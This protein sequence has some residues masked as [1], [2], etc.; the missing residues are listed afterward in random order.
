MTKLRSLLSAVLLPLTVHAQPAGK[1]QRIG[2][3][4]LGGAYE[5]VLQGMR[6]GMKD[7][8]LT[9]GKHFVLHI[10]DTRGSLRD[11][12]NSAKQLVNERVDLLFT[13]TTSATLAT[14]KATRDIPIVFYAGNDPVRAGL[15]QSF[16]QPGDRLT[17]VHHRSTDLTAKRL[18]AVRRVLPKARRIVMFFNPDLGSA[19]DGMTFAR[20]VAPKLGFEIVER[21]VKSA[22]ELLAGVRALRA[23]EVD[24]FVTSGDAIQTSAMPQVLPLARERNLPVV[25]QDLNLVQSGALMAYGANYLDVGRSAAKPIQRILA[26]AKPQDI[27]VEIYDKVQL[28]LNL[29]VARELGL[30]IPQ[31]V[32]LRADQ[33]IH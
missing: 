27:P 19:R 13:I 18:E 3:I 33:V 11:V 14:K 28:A 5:A 4:H 1:V 17:G 29:R 26:G 9:E 32:I 15:V 22:E 21:P 24:V 2:V 30:T 31:P 7:A 6:I 16:A 8:G 23:G 20:G 12:E 25:M 10:R